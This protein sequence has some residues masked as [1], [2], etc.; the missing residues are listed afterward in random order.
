[1]CAHNKSRPQRIHAGREG[2]FAQSRALV[3]SSPP[4][5]ITQG[6]F[7]HKGTV[8]LWMRM[9]KH[10]IIAHLMDHCERYIH[11]CIFFIV[12]PKRTRTRSASCSLTRARSRVQL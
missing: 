2:P 4:H 12:S 5:K 11:H 6:Y 7:P 1:M 3:N 10:G 8:I 9:Y